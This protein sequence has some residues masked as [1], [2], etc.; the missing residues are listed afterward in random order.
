MVIITNN[1][2]HLKNG[3]RVFNANCPHPASCEMRAVD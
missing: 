2:A 1:N 3:L